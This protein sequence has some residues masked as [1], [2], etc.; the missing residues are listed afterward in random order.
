M[1]NND[2]LLYEIGELDEEVPAIVKEKRLMSPV[3]WAAAGSAA[4]AAAVAGFMLL[5]GA[6]T[7]IAPWSDYRIYPEYD[8]KSEIIIDELPQIPCDLT[9]IVIYWDMVMEARHYL[10]A[11]SDIESMDNGS[12]WS[13]ETELT[14]LPVFE[15]HIAYQGYVSTSAYLPEEELTRM[16]ENTVRALDAELISSEFYYEEFDES[17]LPSWLSAECKGEKYGAEAFDITVYGTGDI[18]ITFDN[19]V[20]LPEEYSAEYPDNEQAEKVYSYLVERFGN[21]LQYEKPALSHYSATKDP[22]GDNCCYY[23]RSEGDS[24]EQSIVNYNTMNAEFY[25][26]KQG[27]FLINLGSDMVTSDFV[28]DYPVISLERAR[29]LMLSGSYLKRFP[30][31]YFKEGG[32]LRE[33]DVKR[34]ELIYLGD[35]DYIQ[36][37]YRFYIEL[38][39]EAGEEDG[40]AEGTK[41]YGDVYVP[42]IEAEYI[43]LGQDTPDFSGSIA[44]GV[45]DAVSL[46]DGSSA[47]K[48]DASRIYGS[49]EQPMLEFN[50]GFLR[51]AE[52]IMQSTLDDPDC[53]DFDTGEFKEPT[54]TVIENPDYFRV[55]AGDVLENGM[56]V[57][58]ANFKVTWDG[59][60]QRFL[61]SIVVLGGDVSLEGILLCRQNSETVNGEY[62]LAYDLVFYPDPV[63][64]APLPV[65]WDPDGDQRLQTVIL[66]EAAFTADSPAFSLGSTCAAFAEREGYGEL[67]NGTRAVRARVNLTKLNYYIIN[68]NSDYN[69][70]STSVS[71]SDF[72]ILK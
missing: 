41:L 39:V 31:S 26:N 51:Y 24:A 13:E 17:G 60:E 18:R 16:L 10:T 27:L 25:V 48:T 45:P 46:P 40:Y 63:K 64:E 21:L 4:A 35:G 54:D 70:G 29:E 19:G 1:K 38:G 62:D 7:A 66:D 30:D 42:A 55:K 32:A 6:E 44:D 50:F 47:S 53:F 15:N 56:T 67:I 5:R 57:E 9:N 33:E 11:S 22:D 14:A 72:E 68:E 34:A 69:E 71:Y 28:G 43:L 12:P 58:S 3:R 2:K 23:I 20:K 37:Y 61:E 52:P 59:G 8:Y 65:F 49:K 36:P